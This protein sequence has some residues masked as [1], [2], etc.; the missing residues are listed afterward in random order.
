M[1]TEIETAGVIVTGPAVSPD[2]RAGGPPKLPA[3]ADEILLAVLAEIEALAVIE[4]HR[5]IATDP[6]LAPMLS[7]G[8]PYQPG[9]WR[10]HPPGVSERQALSRAVRRLEQ[11]GLLVRVTEPHRDRVTHLRPTAAGLQRALQLAGSQADP[12]A[13]A[14]GLRE[15]SWGRQLAALIASDEADDSDAAWEAWAKEAAQNFTL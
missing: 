9:Q 8:I 14:V 1:A 10:N 12:A 5:E 13:V 7:M 4:P 15:T 2:A 6:A 3:P 11:V